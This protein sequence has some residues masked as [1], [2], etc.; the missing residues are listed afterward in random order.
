M[1]EAL[2]L[3]SNLEPPAAAAAAAV[4]PTALAGGADGSAPQALF[5]GIVA[6]LLEAA[7]CDA[8]TVAVTSTPT[9]AGKGDEILPRPGNALPPEPLVLA[10]SL[11][12]ALPALPDQPPV[13][14]R[15]ADQ[16][17]PVL[18][19]GVAP[20]ST[21]GVPRP[22]GG[23]VAVSLQNVA[24]N[25]VPD[26]PVAEI[27][28]A[29]PAAA[30]GE[31]L[32]SESRA[33]AVDRLAASAAAASP[34]APQDG[35]GFAAAMPNITHAA[36]APVSTAR[37]MEIP[38][39]VQ[40]NG[41]GEA[42]GNRVVWLAN[43]QVQSAELHLNPPQL[44]P[45]EVQIR[46]ADNQASI[47]FGAHHAL[48]REAI[49]SALPRLREMFAAQG[50]NLADVNVSQQ[51]FAHGR[52]QPAAGEARASAEQG[53]GAAQTATLPAA[54]ERVLGLVDLYA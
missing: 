4:V 28:T 45:I 41:W 16:A 40:Q 29:L 30:P 54:P 37:P 5:A 7:M 11:P 39:P 2:P 34:P 26:R 32:A 44:G 3:L 25:A 36:S 38:V 52:Q 24:Q 1:P 12:L 20:A 23:D 8:D 43:Q 18:E 47:E 33:A 49:E 35:P 21:S 14:E 31:R 27:A 17:Q 53:P 9:E 46:M 10:A 15:P 6:E 50:L 19:A 22:V 48:V 42:L 13:A 51:S